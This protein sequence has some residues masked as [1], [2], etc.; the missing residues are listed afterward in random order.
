MNRL[1]EWME[2]K[3]ILSVRSAM[4]YI[5]VWMTYD[6]TH[7]GAQFAE[8][9]KLTNGTDIA[10]IIAAAT[11]PITAFTTFVYKFYSDSRPAV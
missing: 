6:A 8:T 10:L 1:L 7:W 2:R 5:S 11:A 4:L 3:N 9:T